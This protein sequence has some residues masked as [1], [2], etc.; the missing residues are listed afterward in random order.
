[1]P[2]RLSTATDEKMM[3]SSIRNIESS[4]ACFNFVP[5]KKVAFQ[6][7]IMICKQMYYCSLAVP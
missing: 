4:L 6:V 3:I 7:F 5:L 2:F 1:L